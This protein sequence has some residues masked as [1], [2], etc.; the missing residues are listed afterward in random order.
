MTTED[1]GEV[2]LKSLLPTSA[3]IIRLIWS[4]NIKRNPFG[5]LIR[6]KACLCVHGGIQRERIDFCNTFVPVVNW[7]TVRLIIMMDEMAVW[8]SRQINHFLA[9][10]KSPIDSGIY[11]HLPARFHVYGED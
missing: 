4:F 11:L 9:F 7:F 3:H 6:H 1:V 2:L 10:S 5:E 8:K